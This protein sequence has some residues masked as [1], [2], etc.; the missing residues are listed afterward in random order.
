[1]LVDLESDGIKI[2]VLAH[3]GMSSVNWNKSISIGFASSILSSVRIVLLSV[4]TSLVGNVVP[5][6]IIPTSIASI[7]LV[8]GGRGGAIN[9]LLL[10]K[11][12]L[13]SNSNAGKVFKSGSG[14]EGPA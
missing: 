3:V 1:M 14:G 9:E 6:P 11:I 12:S 8:S 7:V 4:K 13:L 5:G 10:G 2:G